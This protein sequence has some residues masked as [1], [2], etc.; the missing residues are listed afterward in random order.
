MPE[1][2]Y[3]NIWTSGNDSNIT[4]LLFHKEMSACIIDHLD[5]NGNNPFVQ[6]R[7]TI[8]T[9]S[10]ICSPILL[11]LGYLGNSLGLYL[12]VHIYHGGMRNYNYFLLSWIA[13]FNLITCV[14][15]TFK[16]VELY[17]VHFGPY[18][19]YSRSSHWLVFNANYLLL[20]INGFLGAAIILLVILLLERFASL[21]K[22]KHVAPL[23]L[24]RKKNFIS[25]HNKPHETYKGLVPFN[26]MMAIPLVV[27]LLSLSLCSSSFF[28]YDMDHC[29]Y[30]P[31]ISI[32]GWSSEQNYSLHGSNGSGSNRNDIIEKTGFND[33]SYFLC[34]ERSSVLE[35]SSQA[36]VI[37]NDILNL[38]LSRSSVRGSPDNY[39]I[40]PNS[41]KNIGVLAQKFSSLYYIV[42]IYHPVWL[43][44]YDKFRII[45][46]TI[47][48]AAFILVLG[49]CITYHVF[50]FMAIRRPIKNVTP[51]VSRTSK[52]FER[53]SHFNSQSGE[54]IS[55]NWKRR[56]YFIDMS[57]LLYIIFF[58]ITQMPNIT[59][60]MFR[61]RLENLKYIGKMRVSDFVE[62]S[63]LI[64]MTFFTLTFYI[65]ILFDRNFK[66]YLRQ[67]IRFKTSPAT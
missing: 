24:S 29:I 36:N 27:I 53:D 37:V 64:E 1:S 63:N 61:Q 65:Y 40:V 44:I 5:N 3:S 58:I 49:V 41:L 18:G 35:T 8:E 67:M 23:R 22:P 57:C 7:T 52:G 60:L 54:E 38:N 2:N 16:I 46:I 20:L 12:C 56:F 47:L 59:V 30:F 50:K 6:T 66:K 43:M 13:G 14:F 42:K 32:P 48:P 25:S 21:Y 19:K 34:C 10:M 15:S 45:L 17:R 62:L 9:I 28:W 31:R 4:S 39:F 11:T 33:C 26:Y 51:G 55:K